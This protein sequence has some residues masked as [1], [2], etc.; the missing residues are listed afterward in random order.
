MKEIE[1][2]LSRALTLKS[3]TSQGSPLLS[4]HDIIYTSEILYRKVLFVFKLFVVISLLVI[5]KKS[6][7]LVIL[8]KFRSLL[9]KYCV[10]AQ[11]KPTPSPT[12]KA[13][14]REDEIPRIAPHIKVEHNPAFIENKFGIVLIPSLPNT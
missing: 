13:I 12:P 14:P 2:N 7:E 3:G 4:L 1:D 8:V 6:V 9:G 10:S 5:L 11:F